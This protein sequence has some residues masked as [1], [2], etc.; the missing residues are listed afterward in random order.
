MPPAL[1]HPDLCEHS[2]SS[3]DLTTTET[4]LS[5]IHCELL[6][7]PPSVPPETLDLTALAG[8]LI[9]LAP[10]WSVVTPVPWTCKPPAVLR[11]ST[12]SAAVGSS[13]PLGLPGCLLII[14][15]FIWFVLKFL[16]AH[17]S[18]VWYCL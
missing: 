5:T 4:D 12:P 11:I 8:S 3:L 1:L 7:L 15:S 6:L 16:S 17:S 13:F 9:P 10:P 18:G 2:S 14:I